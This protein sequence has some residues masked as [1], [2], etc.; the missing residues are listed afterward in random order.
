MISFVDRGL[1][2][3][4]HE[5]RTLR[6]YHE[7]RLPAHDSSLP[8]SN[9]NLEHSGSQKTDGDNGT[10][11]RRDTLHPVR[12]LWLVTFGSLFATFADIPIACAGQWVGGTGQRLLDD[13]WLGVAGLLGGLLRLVLAAQAGLIGDWWM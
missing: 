3:L 9:A 1:D 10:Y 6:R 2:C 13:G 7:I 4:Q 8:I 5:E 11:S 12:D